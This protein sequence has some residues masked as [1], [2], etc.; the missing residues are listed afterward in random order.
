M[1]GSIKLELVDA[2]MWACSLPFVKRFCSP[3]LKEAVLATR[4]LSICLDELGVVELV[5]AE[6]V[7]IVELARSTDGSGTLIDFFGAGGANVVLVTST[8][9]A[10]FVFVFVV[11]TVVAE[12]ISWS[13]GDIARTLSNVSIS[14][15]NLVKKSP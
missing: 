1:V 8:A 11:T 12:P 15:A 5:A 13:S 4:L 3:K 7:V 9:A 14:W 6:V 2:S 10:L